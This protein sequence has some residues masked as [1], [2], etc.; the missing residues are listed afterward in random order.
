[1]NFATPEHWSHV[2]PTA[3]ALAPV[4]WVYGRATM[5]RMGRAGEVAPVPVICVGNPIAGGAGKTPVALALARITMKLGLKPVFLT[6]GWGGT[7]GPARKVDVAVDDAT[8][9][10]D[11]PLILA[12]TAPT[13]VAY[14]RPEGLDLV[15]R[16]GDVAILDDGFQDP[17]IVKDLSLLVV[18]AGFGVGNGLCIPAGPLRAPIEPQIARADA[19]VVVGVG[20]R[21]DPV[22]RAAARAGKPVL[23]VRVRPHNPERFLGLSTILLAGI[24]RPQKVADTLRAAGATIASHFFFPDHHAFTD[25]E[26][27]RVLDASERT[28]H[29]VV[30]TEKDWVRLAGARSG[31]RF[32]LA[33]RALVLKIDAEFEERS[34]IEELIRSTIAEMRMGR[35]RAA[36]T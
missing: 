6:R 10:G 22:V 13:I 1:M 8:G 9:V 4:G 5:R 15:T 28:G 20:R 17:S 14:P 16:N 18:D 3:L 24:A 26:A 21:A 30:T 35:R 36:R 31:P 25:E 2:S 29:P 12:R 33:R 27:S 34:M 19:L 32:D 7:P 11:E 23:H